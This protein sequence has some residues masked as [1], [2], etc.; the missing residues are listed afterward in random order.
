VLAIIAGA[1]GCGATNSQVIASIS[2]GATNPG[3][4]AGDYIVAVTGANGVTTAT[5]AVSVTVK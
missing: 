5:T 3:T 1:A 4:T 2:S